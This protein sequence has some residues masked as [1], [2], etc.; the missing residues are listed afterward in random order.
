MVLVFVYVAVQLY[1]AKKIM[2]AEKN[3]N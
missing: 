2:Q 1:Q 3:N